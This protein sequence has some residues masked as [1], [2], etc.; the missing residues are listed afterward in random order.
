MDILTLMHDQNVGKALAWIEAHASEVV[1]EAIRICEIPAPTF[2]EAA[3]AAYVRSRFE[4]LELA[5][6]RIDAA[7]N[8]RGRR[9][10]AGDSP[11]L[12]LS[13]HLDTVFPKGTNVIVRR[14]GTRLHAPGIGDNSVGIAALLGILEAL[15]ATGLDTAGDWHLASNTG[16]EGLGDL[17]GMKAF[18]AEVK[19]QVAASIAV[20]G[21]K[22]NRVIHVGVGSRRY[23]FTIT[24]RGGHSW[25]HFPSPS[26]IHLLGRA[27]ADLSRLE[28]P[29]DPKTTYN[30]GVIHGGTTVN[31]IASEADM[32]VDMRSVDTRCLAE[33]E[34]RVLGIVDRTVREG[35]GQ[36]KCELVGDR[37]AG[38]LAADHPLIQTCRA[39]HKALGIETYSE[40]SSTDANVPLGLGLP[41]VCLSVTEG[42]NEHRLDEY[43]E[44]G[45]IA[46]GM[47]SL[48]LTALALTR[49]S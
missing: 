15:R 48:L 46:L 22:L 1:E 30:V 5:E 10:G 37:P 40:P 32:L 31:T 8:V 33:L 43:I 41:G 47:K 2:D 29:S 19:H 21:M 36:V 28:V 39:V 42:A 45:P 6:V 44:T 23:K 14:E 49:A 27:I 12:A 9:K 34:Q 20:E 35:D 26:A 17:K 16:E 18:M 13:A 38:S 11:G 3:R 4:A 25:G 7:G 24:A